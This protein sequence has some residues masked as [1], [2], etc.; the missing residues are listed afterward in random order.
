[1]PNVTFLD[2]GP[3]LLNHDGSFN[4]AI[5]PDHLHLPPAGYQIWADAMGP[6]LDRLRQF[7]S[8]D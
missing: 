3:R 7:K 2:F 6:V 1:L 4:E 5:Q 8:S